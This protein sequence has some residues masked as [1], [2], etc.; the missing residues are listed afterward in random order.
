MASGTDWRSTARPRHYGYV[1]T[2]S[3]RRSDTA[4]STRTPDRQRWSKAAA[5]KD[6]LCRRHST[7]YHADTPLPRSVLPKSR[8]DLRT[9]DLSLPKTVRRAL[10]HGPPDVRNR[11]RG[12]GASEVRDPEPIF[13]Q[14]Q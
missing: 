13:E 11:R 7:A 1:E 6:E 5:P 10:P 9:V 2:C 8:A 12:L 14:A 3:G 4:A